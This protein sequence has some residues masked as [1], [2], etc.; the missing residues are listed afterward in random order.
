MTTTT[1]HRSPRINLR[2]LFTRSGVGVLTLVLAGCGLTDGTS[3]PV[4]ASPRPSSAGADAI[5]VEQSMYCRAVAGNAPAPPAGTLAGQS[6]AAFEAYWNAR[7]QYEMQA[8]WSAPSEVNEAWLTVRRFTRDIATPA[9][10]AGGYQ[11]EFM[12]D[13]PDD[14]GEAEQHID[15]FDREVCKA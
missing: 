1:L 15:Q 4:G 6:S 10:M 8:A 3:E 7:R 9:L 2:A 12:P 14:V 11:R 13:T 5:P